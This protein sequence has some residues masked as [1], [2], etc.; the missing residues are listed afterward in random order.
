MKYGVLP[1]STHRVESEDVDALESVHVEVHEGLGEL[2]AV[3]PVLLPGPG[4]PHARK[5]S[6]LTIEQGQ[7]CIVRKEK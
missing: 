1:Q 5:N 2:R 4:V 3:V 6:I 7:A